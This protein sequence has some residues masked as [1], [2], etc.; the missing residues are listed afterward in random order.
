ML[1][2]SS[3]LKV[4]SP[5]ACTVKTALVDTPDGFKLLTAKAVQ[6]KFGTFM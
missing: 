3:P 1:I 2:R 5:S 4:T 6:K